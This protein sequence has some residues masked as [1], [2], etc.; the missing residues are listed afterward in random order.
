MTVTPCPRAASSRATSKL[1]RLETTG[2]GGK[3]QLTMTTSTSACRRR[4]DDGQRSPRHIDSVRKRC[5]ALP[6][7]QAEVVAKHAVGHQRDQDGLDR[8][9]RIGIEV[10]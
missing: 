1:V 7:T 6:R 4:F 3:T 5:R 2:S 9:D 8:F 10:A